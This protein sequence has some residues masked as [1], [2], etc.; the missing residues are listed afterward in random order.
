[1]SIA[2][3]GAIAQDD[4]APWPWP[5]V[6]HT[7]A[8]PVARRRTVLVAN[9]GD[10]VGAATHLAALGGRGDGRVVVVRPTPGAGDLRTLGLDVLVAA[11][12]RP[13]AAKIERVTAA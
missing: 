7:D 2:A 3:R 12:K 5:P 13:G 1:M 11:G 8:D 6:G 9:F 10:D 4:P